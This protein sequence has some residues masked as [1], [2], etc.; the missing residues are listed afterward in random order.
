MPSRDKALPQGVAS[1]DFEAIREA[2]ME[3]PRGR[4]FLDEFATRLRSAETARLAD[5]LQRIEANLAANHDQLMTRL[6]EALRREP[7]AARAAPQPQAPLAPRHMRYYRADEDIFEPAPG[8]RIAA[9]PPA[10]PAFG[11]L[12]AAAVAEYPEPAPREPARRR[13]VLIR[14]KPGEQIDVPL[15][16]EI[17]EA[18]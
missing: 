14:H 18:S 9:V 13:I 6:A 10:E 1:G 12:A 5:G 2:V 7:A 11:F 16:D 8:A 15:A 17:A 4:W 3:T